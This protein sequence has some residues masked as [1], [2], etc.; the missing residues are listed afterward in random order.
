METP[1][2]A[3]LDDG[4]VKDEAFGL[5]NSSNREVTIESDTKGVLGKPHVLACLAHFHGLDKSAGVQWSL[6]DRIIYPHTFP[7]Q[8]SEPAWN[9]MMPSTSIRLSS[10]TGQMIDVTNRWINNHTL[11][12]V[13]RISKLTPDFFGL[14]RCKKYSRNVFEPLVEGTFVLKAEVQEN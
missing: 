8:R 4:Y 13:L 14:W 12:S 5:T 1:D 6:R 7:D 10:L 9:N 3:K 2:T 11:Y